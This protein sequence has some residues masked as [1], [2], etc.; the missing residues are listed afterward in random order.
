M[1]TAAGCVSH[2]SHGGHRGGVRE[3][4][5]PWGP[6]LRATEATGV[7]GGPGAT[8]NKNPKAKEALRLGNIIMPNFGGS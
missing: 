5:E 6:S 3:P 7:T 1:D 4:R 8:L 2:G